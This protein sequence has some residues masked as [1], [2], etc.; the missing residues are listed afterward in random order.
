VRFRTYD[1]GDGIV[2]CI[3]EITRDEDEVNLL[4][5][6]V[7]KQDAFLVVPTSILPKSTIEI[8]RLSPLL[9]SMSTM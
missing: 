8:S 2:P 5:C 4:R 6:R 1:S 3:W 7:L 9:V